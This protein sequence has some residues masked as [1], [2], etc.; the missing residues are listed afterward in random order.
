[1]NISDLL[2]QPRDM[3]AGCAD[4]FLE[5]FVTQ[6]A[7]VGYTALTIDGYLSSAIHFGGWLEAKGLTLADTN[8]QVIDRFGGH[9]CNC[10]GSRTQKGVSRAY[11]A[12]VQ[13]FVNYLRQNG[14]VS[15]LAVSKGRDSGDPGC[16]SRLA[17]AASR[18]GADH[19]GTA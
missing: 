19:C 9:Q 18:L 8:E 6:L 3:R 1:M 14:A 17:A 12:R 11:I 16:I 10:P 13:R 5:G 2:K 4:I 15:A 7:S